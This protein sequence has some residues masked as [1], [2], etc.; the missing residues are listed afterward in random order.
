M[1]LEEL[2]LSELTSRALE[3]LVELTDLECGFVLE[4]TSIGSETSE[5]TLRA[6]IGGRF[7]VERLA[8]DRTTDAIPA[9]AF[10]TS[11]P[12]VVED[13]R[14]EPALERAPG[15]ASLDIVGGITTV[16]ESRDGPIGLVGVYASHP[17]ALDAADVHFV[18]SIAD[19]L[20]RAINQYRTRRA[21]RASE[22]RYRSLFEDS[23]DAVYITSY[24]GEVLDMNPAGLEMFGY[25]REELIGA[26]ARRLYAD[27]DER[28]RFEAEIAESGSVKDF[29]VELQRKEG[30]V[31]DC[32]V[33]SSAQCDESGEI[34]HYRGIIRDITERKRLEAQL[35]Q[36]ALHD[37]L[38]GLPNRALLRERLKEAIARSERHGKGFLLAFVDLDDFK[39]INDMLGHEAGDRVLEE[40]ADRLQTI[41][42][43]EDTI[44]R[45]GGDEF[46]LLLEHVDDVEADEAVSTRLERVF[47]PPFELHRRAIDLDASIGISHRIGREHAPTFE[48]DDL[49]RAA[50]RAMYRAKRKEGTTFRRFELDARTDSDHSGEASPRRPQRIRDALREEEFVPY[51]QP[52]VSLDDGRIEAVE[53]LARW[54]HPDHGILSPSDFLSSVRQMGLLD[55]M[56]RQ[57]VGRARRDWRDLSETRDDDPPLDLMLNVE[58]DQFDGG[59]LETLF[60]HGRADDPLPPERIGLEITES[61]VMGRR[62]VLAGLEASGYDVVVDDFGTGYASLG[63]LREL[64]I[65]VIKLDRSFVHGLGDGSSPGAIAEVA[66]TLG[67]TLG[68]DVVVEGGESERQMAFVR[69]RPCNRAQGYYFSRP[70]PFE[71]LE[72]LLETS[73]PFELPDASSPR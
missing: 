12:V 40:V 64:T 46:V 2:D 31:M 68:W 60:E 59:L 71:T 24:D 62:E 1:A 72:H 6:A 53:L 66:C 51:Y 14:E 29:E 8:L 43:C 10:E 30:M 34:T 63:Y 26:D 18:Q 42:R 69:D 17:T 20:A 73:V 16:L 28:G 15:L 45:V 19:L 22:S 33:T 67:E 41:F 3:C 36:R 9:R 49:I 52:I 55:A 48:A 58:V 37:W 21:L 25:D 65:D 27:P 50:D 39:E 32:L 38:T 56:T 44:A 13:V 57:L 35:E 47:E 11:A 4:H 54:R 7:D 5:G 61:Q 23:R 70:V